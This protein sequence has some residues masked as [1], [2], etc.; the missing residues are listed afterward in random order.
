[1]ASVPS[2]AHETNEENIN[3]EPLV[4]HLT[5]LRSRLIRAV[6]AVLIASGLCWVFSEILFD[7]IRAPILPFL[8]SATG[9]GLVFTAPMDKF[10]A[11]IKVSL[12]SGV[13]VS[14]PFWI[15]Q[16]WQFV[17]PGLYSKEKKYA[18]AFMFSGTV[19]FLAGVSFVYFVVY[20]LAFDFLMSFGGGTD[21]P[22]ITISDYLSFFT[23]TTIVF[24]LAFELPLILTLLGMAGVIDQRFLR[25]K[26]RFAIVLLAFLSAMATPPDVM[27][28]A[29]MM[30]P[31]LILYESSVIL[32]GIFG[33]QP[34]S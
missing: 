11:H 34:Q 16:L 23:T 21:V 17:A 4:S 15:W 12:F 29:L 14:S 1:V 19:L 3:Q 18:I 33:K 20:P 26:R 2:A 13:I 31:M 32:V 10:L 8:K 22:M 30:V 9:T 5:E 25:E 7:I 28:M 24:G 27:S 6:I